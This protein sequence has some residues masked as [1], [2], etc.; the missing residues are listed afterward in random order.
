MG[1][2]GNNVFAPKDPYTREQSIVTM[3]RLFDMVNTMVTEPN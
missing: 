2:I 3:I 1:G